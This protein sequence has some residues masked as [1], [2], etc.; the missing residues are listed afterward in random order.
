MGTWNKDLYQSRK[1]IPACPR[2]GSLHIQAKVTKPDENFVWC[3]ECRSKNRKYKKKTEEEIEEVKQ[4]RAFPVL[5]KKEEVVL[6]AERK[7]FKAFIEEGIEDKITDFTNN[8]ACSSCCSC[9]NNLLYLSV[10]EI[11]I[12]RNYVLQHKIQPISHVSILECRPALDMMCPFADNIHK[13]CTIYA[14]RPMVCRT[15]NCSK[16][17]EAKRYRDYYANN[18]Q[19]VNMRSTFFK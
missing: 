4:E 5:K 10:K 13:R 2:C 18:R 15:F 1:E 7:S 12:I 16:P 9:C 8:G 19:I 3:A 14:V 17:E 11:K 6:T